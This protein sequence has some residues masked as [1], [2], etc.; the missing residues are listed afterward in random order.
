MDTRMIA[1]MLMSLVIAALLTAGCEKGSAERAGKQVDRAV[2]DFK[3][4][5]ERATK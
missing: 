3:D 2:N 5:V 4:A 1:G